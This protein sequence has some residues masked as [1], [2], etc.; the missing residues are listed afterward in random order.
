MEQVEVDSCHSQ[1]HKA[2]LRRGI[3]DKQKW[4]DQLHSYMHIGDNLFLFSLVSDSTFRLQRN[5]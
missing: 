5:Y 4:E 3:K 1:L 2:Q